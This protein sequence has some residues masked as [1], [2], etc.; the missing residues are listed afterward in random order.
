RRDMTRKYHPLKPAKNAHL[1]DTSE[2]SIKEAFKT[3]CTFIDPL[4]KKHAVK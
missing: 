4:I 3:A 1:L 2:L